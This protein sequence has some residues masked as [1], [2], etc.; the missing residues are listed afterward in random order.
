MYNGQNNTMVSS[1][2]CTLSQYC[3]NDHIRQT[4]PVL[5]VIDTVLDL[6][7]LY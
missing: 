4:L 6:I 5:Q 2:T 7:F 3:Q 1:Y